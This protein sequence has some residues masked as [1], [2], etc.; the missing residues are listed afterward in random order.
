MKTVGKG[1]SPAGSHTRVCSRTPSRMGTITSTGSLCGRSTVILQLQSY[2]ALQGHDDA[3]VLLRLGHEPGTGR[4]GLSRRDEQSAS[5]NV[6]SAA[7]MKK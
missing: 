3:R 5:G 1:P 7:I 6:L 2:L 4:P